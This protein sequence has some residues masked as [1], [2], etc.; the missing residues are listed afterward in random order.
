MFTGRLFEIKVHLLSTVS[1]SGFQGSRNFEI[2]RVRQYLGNFT[3]LAGRVNANVYKTESIFTGLGHGKLSQFLALYVHTLLNVTAIVSLFRYIWLLVLLGMV[4]IMVTTQ[5][6]RITSFL[7]KPKSV[8]LEVA[9]EKEL[10]FPAITICNINTF[11]YREYPG[12]KWSAPP[13]SCLIKRF[14]RIPKQ[15]YC[16]FDATLFVESLI[17]YNCA[18]L[19]PC[20]NSS[21]CFEKQNVKRIRTESTTLTTCDIYLTNARMKI[22][23][24]ILSKRC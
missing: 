12:I 3:G 4:S 17:A 5:I 6:I 18:N 9:Y 8:N 23:Y 10:G 16:N 20:L 14:K 13:N 7:D 21:S 19:Y 2:H 1:R 15:G 22:E 24:M 11:R